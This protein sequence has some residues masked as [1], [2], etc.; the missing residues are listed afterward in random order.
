MKKTYTQKEKI[1]LILQLLDALGL[2]VSDLT[3][4]LP[5]RPTR[6]SGLR[7]PRSGNA[8]IKESIEA[9]FDDDD[10]FG[11]NPEELESFLS[12]HSD[13][14]IEEVSEHSSSPQ[15][16][17]PMSDIDMTIDFELDDDDLNM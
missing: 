2:S 11:I 16:L 12:R 7:L 14:E 13:T 4:D 15:P 3:E 17:S 9:S 1:E 5:A 8:K 10:S 6:E